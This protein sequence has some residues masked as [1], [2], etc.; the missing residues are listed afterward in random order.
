MLKVFV[1]KSLMLHVFLFIPSVYKFFDGDSQGEM[2][3]NFIS[4]FFL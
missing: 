3:F 2:K 1:I 4:D